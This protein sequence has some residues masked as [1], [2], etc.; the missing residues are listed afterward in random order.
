MHTNYSGY[1]VYFALFP[2]KLK[3]A[4]AGKNESLQI[5]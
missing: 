2:N 1:F 5:R 3:T 4:M